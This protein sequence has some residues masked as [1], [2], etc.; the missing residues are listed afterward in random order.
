MA[1]AG[2]GRLFTE[3]SFLLGPSSNRL[4]HNLTFK[5][6]SLHYAMFLMTKSYYRLES[7]TMND[8]HESMFGVG[9]ESMDEVE[10]SEFLFCLLHHFLMKT[11][12]TNKRVRKAEITQLFKEV[13]LT[14]NS[15]EIKNNEIEAIVSFCIFDD[16]EGPKDLS[17]TKRIQWMID[18][19]KKKESLDR[20]LDPSKIK[21]F[22]TT[23]LK[24]KMMLVQEQKAETLSKFISL[25]QYYL[26]NNPASFNF[27]Y[28]VLCNPR[29][30]L[31]VFSIDIYPLAYNLTLAYMK[32]KEGSILSS[33]TID[34][35]M[36][37]YDNNHVEYHSM[38]IY[39][40][41]Q[42]VQPVV[43]QST[44]SPTVY[45]F[46][47]TTVGR[48][49]GLVHSA[50]IQ[51][52][53]L[54][55]LYVVGASSYVCV[56]TIQMD[57]D[58]TSMFLHAPEQRI[59][60]YLRP[61]H[62]TLLDA[63]RAE[64]RLEVVVRFEED[65]KDPREVRYHYLMHMDGTDTV[66]SM[67]AAIYDE[68]VGGGGAHDKEAVMRE[69][70]ECIKVSACMH[71][72]DHMYIRLSSSPSYMY[73][74]LNDLKIE[75]G[76]TLRDDGW[77]IGLDKNTSVVH[78]VITVAPSEQM[79]F[80]FNP[81]SSAKFHTTVNFDFDYFFNKI[82][83][84]TINWSLLSPDEDNLSSVLSYILPHQYII[85]FTTI[86]DYVSLPNKMKLSCLDSITS[87]LDIPTNYRIKGMLISFVNP[88]SQGAM[89]PLTTP[90][91][92]NETNTN[93]ETIDLY[94]EYIQLSYI[95]NKYYRQEMD[96]YVSLTDI[97]IHEVMYIVLDRY[98]I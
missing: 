80:H 62:Q 29:I 48:A 51:D 41:I 78:L 6:K 15:R 11:I 53:C 37:Y 13:L 9:E 76:D 65:N 10:P 83:A 94:Y 97:S 73:A 87:S 23:V 43:R 92:E 75:L 88:S 93:R 20:I 72:E 8:I 50:L 66:S 46:M 30:D 22:F 68:V 35:C 86:S 24:P 5:K 40:H 85:D 33:H 89:H 79:N 34:T 27:S 60:F 64:G 56:Q 26:L 81:A 21:H 3:S 69:L 91:S 57:D 96:E 59:G 14:S 12:D 52:Y 67:I 98:C 49:G 31:P 38:N 58:I 18:Y 28:D 70:Y 84:N 74:S 71:R 19:V 25:Y 42:I 63:V 16:F 54:K 2:K 17:P 47:K 7:I 39:S 55:L 1:Q 4:P 32:V 36:I 45:D 61:V 44:V 77:K 95:N 90:G 82:L